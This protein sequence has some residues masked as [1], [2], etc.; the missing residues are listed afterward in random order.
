MLGE[1]KDAIG[2]APPVAAEYHER[3][4]DIG[5]RPRHDLQ[6]ISLP[7]A[8][9]AGGIQLASR[10]QSIDRGAVPDGPDYHRIGAELARIVNDPRLPTSDTLN[11]GCE[12][13]RGNANQL[14]VFRIDVDIG[15]RPPENEF[16]RTRKI[17][18]PD[19]KRGGGRFFPP[20]IRR[21][22]YARA[23]TQQYGR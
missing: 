15:H 5:K 1:R 20:R 16:H 23:R 9:H 17:L 10:D 4:F 14:H 12:K 21:R 18:V 2:G 11:V 8:A 6:A 22:P 19:Q 13:T 3:A 7:L